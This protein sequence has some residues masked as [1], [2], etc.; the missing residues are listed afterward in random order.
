MK[1]RVNGV[2]VTVTEDETI[3]EGAV[4][5]YYAEFE[6]DSSWDSYTK[7]A[8]F[9]RGEE[10]REMTLAADRCE[11]PWEVLQAGLGDLLSVGIRGVQ[12]N[13]TRPTLWAVPKVVHPGATSGDESKEPTPDVIQQIIN[14]Q[15]VDISDI[16]G[17][18]RVTFYDSKGAKSFEVMDG[19]DYTLT[20]A[21]KVEI[22]QRAAELI[23]TE[24]LSMIGEVSE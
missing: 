4:K 15:K 22:A 2:G 24:L 12:A 19:T 6:F 14:L 20:E 8:V 11:I 7:I 17:G 10:S 21:D 23:D 9:K 13:K 16:A 1:Y 18:H 5:V 3:V